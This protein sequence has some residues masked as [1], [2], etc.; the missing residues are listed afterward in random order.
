MEQ[1]CEVCE[2]FRPQGDLN[3]ARELLRVPFGARSVLLCRG[4]AGIAQNS[5]VTTIEELR[6]LYAESQGQRSYIARRARLAQSQAG[7]ARSAGRR[8]GDRAR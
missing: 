4:H 8:A 3:A 1:R 6:A 5:G 7:T 2:S